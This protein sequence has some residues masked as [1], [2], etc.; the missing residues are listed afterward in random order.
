MPGRTRLVSP[1]FPDARTGFAID[2]YGK[3]PWRTTDGG[4][5]WTPLPGRPT[6]NLIT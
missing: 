5:S 4:S 1:Q 3:Q 6:V 2:H